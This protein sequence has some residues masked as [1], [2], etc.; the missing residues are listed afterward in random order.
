MPLK[1]RF[2]LLLLLPVTAILL[3]V[4]TGGFFFAQKFL[5]GQWSESAQLRLA[6]VAHEIRMR[7]DEKL[8]L[9]DLIVQAEDIPDHRIAQ[10]FLIGRL[11]QT[12]GV[13][14]VEWEPYEA[15]RQNSSKEGNDSGN[16]TLTM[17]PDFSE[18]ALRIVRIIRGDNE[19][20]TKQLVVKVALDSFL[21]H[22]HGQG[23]WKGSSACLVTADGYYLAHTDHSM[24]DRKMLGESGDP[25][26]KGVLEAIKNRRYGT[27]FGKGYPPDLVMGFYRVPSTDW[28]IIL[29][30]KGSVILQPIVRFSV[31]YMLISVGA[32]AM[33]FVLIRSATGSVAR[34]IGQLSH[35]ARTIENGDYTSKLPEVGA[36]EIGQLRR[37]FNQMMEGLRQRGVIQGIFGRYV[38]KQ[39]A[40]E[41]LR[42]PELL[43]MGGEE[44]MVTILM[45]DLI[46]F[47]KMAEKY[48]PE[49][50]VRALNRYLSGMIEIIFSHKGLIVDFFGGGI[51]AF[52]D[53]TTASTVER[54]DDA[55]KCALEMRSQF[56]QLQGETE[57]MQTVELVIGIHTGKVIVGNVGSDTRTKYGIVG[58]AVNLTERIKSK[59]SPGSILVSEETYQVLGQGLKVGPGLKVTLKGMEHSRDL[60][61]VTG[62]AGEAVDS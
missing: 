41:L 44:R 24:H 33:I 58:S 50:T 55:V 36:D 62:I 47:A 37:N 40:Q 51:L 18:N 21:A 26:E 19:N 52:F 28:Y 45:A 25:L 48:P 31:Y 29:F 61:P 13:R 4:G 39:L 3:V 60:Y 6:T 17:D 43:L 59:A 14:S 22:I 42:Q 49:D 9:I 53:G 7:L 35:A 30:S 15:S 23:L 8:R 16:G 46:G 27:I 54:A 1:R 57:A 56:G 11:N 12:E 38:D 34:S 2:V 5:F 10:D 32:I 20:P